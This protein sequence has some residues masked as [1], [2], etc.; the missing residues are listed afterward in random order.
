VLTAPPVVPWNSRAAV[1]Q[2]MHRYNYYTCFQC[3]E[4][5]FGGER[6]CGAAAGAPD[7]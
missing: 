7:G 6:D 5:Y 2:A 3:A 1:A 4:P